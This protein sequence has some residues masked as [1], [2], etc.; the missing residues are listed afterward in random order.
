MKSIT[1]QPTKLSQLLLIGALAAGLGACGGGG[2][3]SSSD[4]E[5]SLTLGLTDAPVDEAEA[6]VVVFNSI[7]LQGPERR[8]ITFDEAKVINLLDYQNGEQ[9]LLLDDETLPA[10]EYQWIRL[11][12][13]EE[14]SYIQI[15]GMQYPLDIPSAAQSGLKLNRGFTLAAAGVSNFTI[16]FDLRKSVHQQG[17]GDYKLRPTL[18]IVDNLEVGSISGVVAEGLVTAEACNNGDNNDMGNS[19]YLFAGTDTA[20]QDVQGNETD[21]VASANVTYNQ[22]TLAWEFTLAFVEAG[23]YSLAFTCDALLDDPLLDNSPDNVGDNAV[24]QFSSSANV[25][26]VADQEQTVELVVPSI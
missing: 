11:G 25:T 6:V 22:Q 2:S 24:V 16:D 1:G 3:G 21:P 15:A 17:T 8:T 7:E 23:D 4:T 10:G 20:A 18:R 5:G 26:V 19:V 12:V 13:D 14:S 9:V